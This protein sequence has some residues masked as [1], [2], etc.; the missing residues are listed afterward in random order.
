MFT[1]S[2][3]QDQLRVEPGSSVS[4]TFVLRNDGQSHE[5]AEVAVQGLDG[6]WVAIP[7]PI[8]S[9]APGESRE[10]RILIKP[11]RAAESRSGAYPFVV[12]ARS[13]ESGDGVEAQSV[14]ELLP[15]NL[16]SLQIEPKRASASFF[17]KEAPFVVTAVTLGNTDQNLQL[18]ADDPVDGCTYSLEPERISLAPGQQRDVQMFAQPRSMPFVGSAQLYGATVTARNIEDPKISATAQAQVERRAALSPVLLLTLVL[19]AAL[20]G[21]WFSMRPKPAAIDTFDVDPVE[22]FVGEEAKLTW[23]ST[24]ARS[25]TIETADGVFMEGLPPSGSKTVKVTKTTTFFIFA[26]NEMGRSRTPKEVTVV[27][28]IVPKPPPAQIVSF[29]VEPKTVSV[30]ATATITYKVANAIKVTLQPLGVDLAVSG[31]DSYSFIAETPGKMTLELTAYNAQNQAVEKSVTLTV[32][33][34]S[35]ARILIFRALKDGTPLGDT[36]VEPSTPIQIE[37]QVTNAARIDVVPPIGISTD[38]GTLELVAPEQTTTYTLTA[39][40]SKGRKS[41]SRL[42]LNIEKTSSPVP[43]MGPSGG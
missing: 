10:D 24:N 36:K 15:I 40:D 4:L 26:V 41:V 25:V 7:V 21:F 28:K 20:G 37:W 22:V 1:L 42:K 30:G 34:Q 38:K 13:L 19:I 11:P 32:V 16:I 27:A 31:Q 35:D 3:L 18:F 29:D 33:D 5:R 9:L 14:L 2:L 17:R 39:T 23:A 8:L 6:D 12:Q 43:P